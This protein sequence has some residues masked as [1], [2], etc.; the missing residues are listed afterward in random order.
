[1]TDVHLGGV[2]LAFVHIAITALLSGRSKPGSRRC[3]GKP[4]SVMSIATAQLA[5]H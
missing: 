1:M 2:V 5:R 3:M 4:E